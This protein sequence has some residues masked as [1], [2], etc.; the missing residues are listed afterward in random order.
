MSLEEDVKQKFC[1]L[2][3]ETLTCLGM[4]LELATMNEFGRLVDE[5]LQ[6]LIASTPILPT[7]TIFCGQQVSNTKV[8][9]Q[10][11]YVKHLA[12]SLKNLLKL[13]YIK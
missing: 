4:L 7:Y 11:D 2:L 9:L 10:Q 13:Y 6:Y 5:L 8:E 12:F 3:Q 1:S